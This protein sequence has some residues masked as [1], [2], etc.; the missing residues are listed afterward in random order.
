MGG[1]E[2]LDA[3]AGPVTF[4][5]DAQSLTP[6][7]NLGAHDGSRG[8]FGTFLYAVPSPKGNN[9]C[10]GSRL[11]WTSYLYNMTQ[12]GYASDPSSVV[13]ESRFN[14]RKRARRRRRYLR[15]AVRQ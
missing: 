11:G 2:A 12:Y 1:G 13:V 4:G 9:P 5:A 15:L 10:P 14:L 7:P 3:A 8:N 6:N